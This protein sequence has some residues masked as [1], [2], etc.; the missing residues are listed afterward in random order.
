[1][2]KLLFHDAGLDPWIMQQAFSLRR[3]RRPDSQGFTLG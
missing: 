3:F 2:G 1:M